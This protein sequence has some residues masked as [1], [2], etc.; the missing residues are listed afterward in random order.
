VTPLRRAAAPA[1]LAAL[2][3]STWAGVLEV[4]FHFDDY[5]TIVLDPA[6]RDPAALW[7]R[8]SHGVRPLLRLSFFL[9]HLLWGHAPLGF[10][11]TNL[12]LH[13]L[14]VLG[15]WALARRRL[16]GEVA[17]FIAAA[18]F[19]LQPANAE[20]VAYVSGRSTGLATALLVAALLAHER[21]WHAAS[22][23]LAGA[24]CLAKEVA[25]IFP[26]LLAA[27]EL[28]R[29]GPPALRWRRATAVA[30]AVAGALLALLATSPRYRHLLAYSL[31]LRDPLASLGVNLAAVPEMLSLWARPWALSVDHAFAPSAVAAAGGLAL[32]AAAIAVA[33]LAR[34]RA[35]IVTL[36]I[37]WTLLALAPTSSFIAKLDPVT[38]K[39]L[40][41]AWI[42]PSLAAGALVAR[43]RGAAVAAAALLVVLAV[44]AAARVTVWRDART[45]WADAVARAPAN[46]RA[47]NNLG[48]AYVDAGDVAAARAAFARAVRLDPQDVTARRNLARLDDPWG[49]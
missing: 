42:G 33:T 18:L 12:A 7:W 47:W 27:W 44:S 35:P 2:T 1:L 43:S 4:P 26:A 45:L 48:K 40:Y 23:A 30:L 5:P 9:D 36:A 11:A 25:L 13:V 22:V 34:R 3:L 20:V 15:V 6:T 21:A 19:A 32:L 39:P 14:T 10:H 24:A 31:G 38:E 17:P 29:G 41:L 46:G 16:G 37:V 8:L 49:F 28:T